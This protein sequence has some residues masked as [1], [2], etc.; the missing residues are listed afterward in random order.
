MT[1]TILF[2]VS[3]IFAGCST[4]SSAI[5]NLVLVQGQH[6]GC[7]YVVM[8]VKK[9]DNFLGLET[10]VDHNFY[11]ELFWCCPNKDGKQVMC[12]EAKWKLDPKLVGK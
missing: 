12:T 7:A 2:L 1:R 10:T 8:D 6:Q 4:K 9:T 5:K 11:D 3:S